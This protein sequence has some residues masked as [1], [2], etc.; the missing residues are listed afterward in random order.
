MARLRFRH[1]AGFVGALAAAALSVA[2]AP[3]NSVDD[4]AGAWEMSLDGSYRKCRVTL[5]PED[6]GSARPLRKGRHPGRADELPISNQ[7][8]D[9]GLAKDGAKAGQK[10]AP[11]SRGGVPGS[12]ENVPHH[13]NGNALMDDRQHQDIDVVAAKLPT[14]AVEG[15]KPRPRSNA[16]DPD[17]HSGELASI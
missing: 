4:A 11:L 1:H 8:G 3:L 17:D 7:S 10:G 2:A 13:R 12:A 15:Q 14:R 5:D 6:L 9:G 16:C